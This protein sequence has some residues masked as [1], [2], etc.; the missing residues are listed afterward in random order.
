MYSESRDNSTTSASVEISISPKDKH[1]HGYFF[2]ISQQ[3]FYIII[4]LILIGVLILVVA[5]ISV[6]Y[7]LHKRAFRQFYPASS[8]DATCNISSIGLVCKHE[9]GDKVFAGDAKLGI[10][11]NKERK[12]YHIEICTDQRIVSSDNQYLTAD[13]TRPVEEPVKVYESLEADFKLSLGTLRPN[14]KSNAPDSSETSSGSE[15]ECDTT[16]KEV[17]RSMNTDQSRKDT[18]KNV[19]LTV[20]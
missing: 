17:A 4:S 2:Q 19:Y 9:N 14:V 18:D 11:Y 8:C 16:V 10:F 12:T 20:Y 15:S 13:E 6:G 7:V 5:V 3:S 1:K